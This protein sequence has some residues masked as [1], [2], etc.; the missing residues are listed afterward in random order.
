MEFSPLK[1]FWKFINFPTRQRYLE[2]VPNPFMYVN[3]LFIAAFFINFLVLIL[4]SSMLNNPDDLD[5]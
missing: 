1:D 5:F 3:T 4:V 2:R